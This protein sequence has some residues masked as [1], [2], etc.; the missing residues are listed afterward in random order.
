[1][2]FEVLKQWPAKS[3][4]G[5]TDCAQCCLYHMLDVAAVAEKLLPSQAFTPPFREA[6]VF[7]VGIHDLGKISD[8]FRNMLLEGIPQ[9][10]RHW[11]LSEAL[12]Y[13]ND[14][15]LGAALGSR[16][17]RRQV[18][19]GAVAGHHGVPSELD[20][21]QLPVGP[22]PS[23]KLRATIAN[24]GSGAD[25]ARAHLEALASLW[26]DASLGEVSLTDAKRLSWWLAG[27]CTV[28]DWIGSNTQWFPPQDPVHSPSKYLAIARGLAERAVAEAGVGGAHVRPGGLFDFSFR[29][30]Q[31]KAVE[32]PLV[33]G[34]M[35]AVIE[36]ETGAGKTEAALMLAQR[37]LLAGKGRG[38]YFALPT[39]ATA[40]AMFSR[41]AEV[42][43]RLFDGHPTL[44]LAHGK[45][46]LSRAYAALPDFPD[47]A[48]HEA[49]SPGSATCSEWLRSNARRALLADVGV[50][51]IDQAL[52]ATL[53][54]RFQTLR[55]WGL[56]SK[57]LIVDEVH[58]M[59]VPYMA[60]ELEALLRMHRAQGGSAILLT[61]TLPLDQRARLLATYDGTSDD[62]A[63]PA[64]TIA[65]GAAVTDLPTTTGARGAVGVRRLASAGE[66]VQQ[67][68]RA[69]QQGA[70]CVWVRNAVDDAIAAVETLRAAGCQAD[71]LHARMALCDRKRVEAEMRGR[72]GR[73]GEGRAGRV[74]VGTQVL[75]SSLDLDFD[76]MISDLA[77]MA[78]LIQR[79][80]RLWRHMDC[81]PASR[82]PVPAPVL[83]VI[84]PDPDHVETAHWLHGTLD[85][86]AFVYPVGETW[87]TARTLFDTGRIVAPSGLRT[88]IE[89]VHGRDACALPEALEA[90]E[91]AH[92][93]KGAAER[94]HA[95]QNIVDFT[96]GYRDA[97][98]GDDDTDYPTRLGE[99]QRILVLA[100][101]A[102]DGLHPWAEDAGADA[103]AL[104]EVGAR[105]TTL[106]ALPL[107]DQELPDIRAITADWPDWKRREMRLCPVAED[108][109]ICAGL[110]Y[111][112]DAGLLFG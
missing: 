1:M 4:V 80:G 3:R 84:S 59:G 18:L 54:I 105:R 33:D 99:P 66:A 5:E 29:P 94:G 10:S 17:R 109:T 19:Y 72:F 34:P 64:L 38:L 102:D 26:P 78:A 42:L 24:I 13:L 15:L 93:G 28:A 67:L 50:G 58:E 75:E 95:A 39:M 68:V 82:R 8:D 71:L 85:R 55:G 46:R 25:P 31:R 62:P 60:A 57:I 73:D 112:S 81:R 41:T 32:I 52:L 63:Y 83:Q 96:K 35:L 40:D 21:G 23:P 16:P 79:A 36:D 37:M 30:M 86:G 101:R 20:L 7:L 97:G 110:R 90:E 14:D 103:W 92:F 48:A 100:R 104:S 87:R 70:A 51:T 111:R 27:L 53:P 47:L 11:K 49:E 89:A 2:N 107:P 98:R 76:F 12:Y 69:A 9:K 106:D 56:S 44:T 6:L 74:L 88:L 65:R 61:A 77:P 22:R 43:G 91:I 45:A 108:G